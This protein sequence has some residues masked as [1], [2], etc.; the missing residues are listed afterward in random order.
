MSLK[1]PQAPPKWIAMLDNP[2]LSF[3]Q[4]YQI[5]PR[6]GKRRIE[7]EAA[8]VWDFGRDLLIP[9]L[10]NLM[11]HK[12]TT[13]AFASF[14]G[15]TQLSVACSF[16]CRESRGTRLQKRWSSTQTNDKQYT[17]VY[18]LI[19]TYY[20]Y[21]RNKCGTYI[22]AKITRLQKS[23]SSTQTAMTNSIII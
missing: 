17:P 3:P 10:P 16:A 15:P 6:K 20:C 23:R 9:F 2:L 1:L 19:P 8:T 12:C 4:K 18:S 11:L 13:E 5:L 14:P 21:Y 22:W 7:N